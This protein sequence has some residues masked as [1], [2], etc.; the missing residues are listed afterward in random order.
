MT[1]QQQTVGPLRLQLKLLWPENDPLKVYVSDLS[2]KSRIG[3]GKLGLENIGVQSL[4]NF[5]FWL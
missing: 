3:F 5:E 1:S 4:C 2:P